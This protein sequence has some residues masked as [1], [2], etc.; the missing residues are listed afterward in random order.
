MG[1]KV[2]L[3]DVGKRLLGYTEE[4]LSTYSKIE[5][6]ANDEKAV[7]G[8]LKIA[9]PE[10]L[11]VYRLE[12]ILSEYR[13]KYPHVSIKLSNAT[14][15]DNQKA[16]LNGS[17]DVSFVMLPELRDSNLTVHLLNKEPIVVVGSPDS[18][19]NVLNKKLTE[20]LISN[21][22]DCIY[23]TMFEK[24]LEE[25]EITSSQ[26]ME[27]WSIEAIKQCVMSGLGIT[28]LPFM[29]VIEELHQEKL[30][31]IPC[32]GGFQEIFSQV[33]YHK[34][35]WIS[36]ALSEFIAITLKHAKSWS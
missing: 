11:T 24:Y 23:R 17:A 2:K 34:N 29:T 6:I 36:P 35:K 18:T 12:P 32:E 7:R 5:N 26:I 25:R 10:S 13:K 28:C 27:L 9:A 30:K 3:T 8:E 21:G 22:K 20:A 16:L 14:C 1:R 4:I 33:A 19:M 15:G 31:I